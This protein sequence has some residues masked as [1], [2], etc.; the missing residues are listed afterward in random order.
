MALRRRRAV[1]AFVGIAALHAG[2]WLVAMALVFPA[3]DPL[4]SYRSDAQWLK[5]NLAPDTELGF[6]DGGDETTKRAGVLFYG[7][8]RL[9]PFPEST[10][11][12]DWMDGDRRR[13]AL[14]DAKSAERLLAEDRGFARRDMRR[15]SVG[16]KAWMVLGSSG[17]ESP[18]RGDASSSRGP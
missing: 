16:E 14:V 2:A 3:F 8:M 1:W 11:L 9:R 10:A 18:A 5:A 17:V 13:I 6:H 7:G 12:L 4:N 15:F